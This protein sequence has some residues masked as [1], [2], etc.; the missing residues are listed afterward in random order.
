MAG[1][2]F[3]FGATGLGIEKKVLKNDGETC[4]A[5]S[6]KFFL[7]CVTRFPERAIGLFN[8]ALSGLSE[9]KEWLIKNSDVLRKAVRKASAKAR[10]K[11]KR[12]VEE[13][14]EAYKSK[15]RQAGLLGNQP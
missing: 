10:V 13:E 4:K 11:A 3:E 6:V 12:E 14:L 8:Q 5:V 2:F 15:C 1:Y 7:V 9:D